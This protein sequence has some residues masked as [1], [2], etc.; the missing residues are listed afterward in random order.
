MFK[1]PT[2]LI[3]VFLFF[4]SIGITFTL[5]SP[6]IGS[7]HV[8]DISPDQVSAYEMFCK[9]YSHLQLCKLEFTLQQALAEL[10][11]IILNDDPTDDNQNIKSKRK[12]AF[13][14]FGK[15]D[16]GDEIVS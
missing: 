6:T 4:L 10:Q 3:T 14:R 12:S 5:S 11:Y 15:R 2:S 16:L 9:D 13:V 7:Q 1:Y 8:S